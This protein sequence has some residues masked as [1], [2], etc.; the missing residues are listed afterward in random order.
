MTFAGPIDFAH[1]YF[2]R[3]VSSASV[4]G[5]TQQQLAID[6]PPLASGDKV[7][8]LCCRVH[9]DVLEPHTYLRLHL[10]GPARYET[11][12]LVDEVAAQTR[13]GP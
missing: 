7:A 10:P 12:A 6:I 5:H 1:H 2:C 11:G 4:L 9:S 8:A 3:L 13:D